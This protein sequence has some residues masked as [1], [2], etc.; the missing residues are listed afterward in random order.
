MALILASKSQSRRIVLEMFGFDFAVE[1]SKVDERSVQ[2]ED[3]NKLTTAIAEMKAKAVAKTHQQD[4]VIGID[5]MVC[6]EKLLIGQPNNEENARE[7]MRLL[8]G[9]W[10]DVYSGYCIISNENVFLGNETSRLKLKL[11][12]D[13]LFEEYISSGSWSG[14]AGGY[15][16]S[17]SK[18]ENFV[19][20]VEGSK[21]N[22]VG[23]PAEKIL[24]LI[25]TASKQ[26][27]INSIEK[28]EAKLF[29]G[30]L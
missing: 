11:I 16:I 1:P 5:T 24:P 27:A 10:P 15:N 13:S 9:K 18:F 4:T 17:D 22:I 26:K 25:E 3:P 6:K 12:D 2:L 19:E 8:L 30:T 7:I 14:K 21:L 20:K 28:V 29:R 23:L